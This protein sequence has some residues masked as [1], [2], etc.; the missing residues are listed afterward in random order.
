MGRRNPSVSVHT[1]GEKLKIDLPN[2]LKCVASPESARGNTAVT[3][4]LAKI[5]NKTTDYDIL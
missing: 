5:S 4:S 1:D 3:V 2:F